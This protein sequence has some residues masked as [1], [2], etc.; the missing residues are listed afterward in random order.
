[1]K[2]TTE[3][4]IINIEL[5]TTQ[6]QKIASMGF[7]SRTNAAAY[8]FGSLGFLTAQFSTVV[9]QAVKDGK[10]ISI[11][12]GDN[13]FILKPRMLHKNKYTAVYSID[14]EAVNSFAGSWE[15]VNITMILKRCGAYPMSHYIHGTPEHC[16]VFPLVKTQ[17]QCNIATLNG[18][19]IDYDEVAYIG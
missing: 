4:N 12:G 5:K 1:M 10:N 16:K 15:A 8:A 13:G 14:G 18:S 11:I 7:L 17:H 19:A 2:Y 6:L 3:G 9:I